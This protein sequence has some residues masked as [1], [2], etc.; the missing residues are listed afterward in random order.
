MIVVTEKNFCKISWTFTIFVINA[1]SK[2]H[3]SKKF[4]ELRDDA[5]ALQMQRAMKRD[6]TNTDTANRVGSRSPGASLPLEIMRR[7]IVWCHNGSG[8]E[9][10][11]MTLID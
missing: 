6:T 4:C 7:M 5:H 8:D 3:G 9:S 11:K 2:S 10:A 1:Q